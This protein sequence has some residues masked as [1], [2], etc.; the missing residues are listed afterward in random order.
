MILKKVYRRR[1]IFV[2]LLV[3][4]DILIFLLGAGA[5]YRFEGSK[6]AVLII[7]LA[8]ILVLFG[9]IWRGLVDNK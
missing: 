1:R 4:K 2:T 3:I 5:A 7:P 9:W 6:G 8:A